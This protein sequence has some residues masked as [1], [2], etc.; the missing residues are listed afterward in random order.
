MLWGLP[1]R[2]IDQKGLK[3]DQEGLKMG[4]EG[5]ELCFF[6]GMK[7]AAC[8]GGVNQSGPSQILRMW[9]AKSI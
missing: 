3:M 8:F 5:L 2:K 9:L 7:P 4:Q 6:M 1:K